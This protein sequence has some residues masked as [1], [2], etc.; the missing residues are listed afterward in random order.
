LDLPSYPP[1]RYA[2]LYVATLGLALYFFYPQLGLLTI[3]CSVLLESKVEKTI[4]YYQ[5]TSRLKGT[6]LKMGVSR[7]IVSVICGD[8]FEPGEGIRLSGYGRGGYLARAKEEHASKI[9]ILENLVVLLSGLSTI[10]LL[11]SYIVSY[12]Y[13]GLELEKALFVVIPYVVFSAT[14]FAVRR[15]GKLFVSPLTEGFSLILLALFVLLQS[16][17]FVLLPLIVLSAGATYITHKRETKSKAAEKREKRFLD[18]L[19]LALSRRGLAAKA[20]AL[21]V[22]CRFFSLKVSDLSY[23]PSIPSIL[24]HLSA[25]TVSKQNGIMLNVISRALAVLGYMPTWYKTS[26]SILRTYEKLGA[27]VSQQLAKNTLVTS[28]M[29]SV[30]SLSIT[31]LTNTAFFKFPGI[32]S[33]AALPTLAL[34]AGY[35]GFSYT[36]SSETLYLA[37][38]FVLL[39]G[40][41]ALRYAI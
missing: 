8:E 13:G 23:N 27:E 29:F 14:L 41:T 32:P 12:V 1:K 38:F 25:R 7:P 3:C 24:G 15:L 16:A 18:E 11:T 5:L 26:W 4:F 9:L 33:Q 17:H 21:K 35:I 20:G 39:L 37:L 2:P 28:V 31:L 6:L 22:A 34:D 30:G 36:N 10:G 19:A 40:Q